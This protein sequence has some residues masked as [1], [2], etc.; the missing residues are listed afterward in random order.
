MLNHYPLENLLYL[1]FLETAVWLMI[2]AW[3]LSSKQKSRSVMFVM[4]VFESRDAVWRWIL[5]S[6]DAL[7]K[8]VASE[9]LFVTS[10]LHQTHFSKFVMTWRRFATFASRDGVGVTLKLWRR[11]FRG[12]FQRFR[13]SAT[14]R[15]TTRRRTSPWRRR[16]RPPSAL[17]RRRS[18]GCSCRERGTF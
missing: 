12:R 16:C 7:V 2:G 15:R 18:G 9:K 17:P 1:S 10:N 14:F 5:W 6:R 4:F 3:K 8:K 11:S 13:T